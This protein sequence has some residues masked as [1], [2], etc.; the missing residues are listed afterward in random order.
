MAIHHAEREGRCDRGI[1]RIAA[2]FDRVDRRI[3]R[4]R[5][6]R[7]NRTVCAGDR[8]ERAGGRENEDANASAQNDD[9][10]ARFH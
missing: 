7:G 2:A 4:Q 6:N 1:D 3:R 8:R 10:A 5:M 9:G